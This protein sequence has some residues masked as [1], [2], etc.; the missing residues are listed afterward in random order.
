MGGR[1]T[2]FYKE[3]CYL[4]GL[5]NA[6]TELADQTVVLRFWDWL[7]QKHEVADIRSIDHV[8]AELTKSTTGP[9][10]VVVSS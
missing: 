5:L 6:S 4:F 8:Y 1:A 3:L 2:V 7:L 10:T 9:I